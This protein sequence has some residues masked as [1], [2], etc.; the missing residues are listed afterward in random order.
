MKA[1]GL[2]GVAFARSVMCQPIGLSWLLVVLLIGAAV[3]DFYERVA[4]WQT[5]RVESVRT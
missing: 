5:Q 2:S 4:K 3:I 1:D